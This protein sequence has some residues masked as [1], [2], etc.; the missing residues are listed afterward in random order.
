MHVEFATLW[1]PH[2]WALHLLQDPRVLGRRSMLVLEGML[3]STLF[4][5]SNSP[6]VKVSLESVT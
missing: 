4:P 1:I 2:L 3:R 5:S 6:A